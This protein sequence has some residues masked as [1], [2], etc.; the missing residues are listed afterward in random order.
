MFDLEEFIKI[1]ESESDFP[2]YLRSKIQSAI[3][4]KNPYKRG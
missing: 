3:I 2:N 4:E 1:I